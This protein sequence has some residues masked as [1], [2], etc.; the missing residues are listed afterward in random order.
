MDCK[1]KRIRSKSNDYEV[2]FRGMTLGGILAMKNALEK[3]VAAGSAVA[4]DV[5]S[6]LVSAVNAL[7]DTEL[8]QV[9]LAVP[10]LEA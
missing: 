8:A 2:T 4:D 9:V 7:E 1:I 5:L 10:D 6:F 3:H